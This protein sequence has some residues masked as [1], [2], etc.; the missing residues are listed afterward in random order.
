MSVYNFHIFT[1]GM[2]REVVALAVL[3]L[4]LSEASQL[5][6]KVHSKMQSIGACDCEWPPPD[7]TSNADCAPKVA[8]CGFCM[9]SLSEFRIFAMTLHANGMF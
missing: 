9:V 3:C 5:R 8:R 4:T 2:L 7:Y 1:M 6:G